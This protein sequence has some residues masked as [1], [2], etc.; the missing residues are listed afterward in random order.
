MRFVYVYEFVSWN[1]SFQYGKVVHRT[2]TSVQTDHRIH[3]HTY[4]VEHATVERSLDDYGR[5]DVTFRQGAAWSRRQSGTVDWSLLHAADFE[6]DRIGLDCWV[7]ITTMGRK[8]CILR[9]YC[10]GR[11]ER[12]SATLSWISFIVNV[13]IASFAENHNADGEREHFPAVIWTFL[14]LCNGRLARFKIVTE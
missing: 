12:H 5:R 14:Q 1:W 10:T 8:R 11:N 2:T 3:E 7:A 4:A 13:D 9:Q 6:L